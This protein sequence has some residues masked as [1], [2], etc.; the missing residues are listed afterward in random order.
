M[1]A[2]A[3]NAIVIGFAVKADNA[4]QRLA[5]TNGISIRTYTVIYRLLEDIEKALK[6]MLEPEKVEKVIGTARVLATFV[7]SRY[8]VAAGCRV[9]DGEIRR[10][11]KIRVI[12]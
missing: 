5:E 10:N 6:G 8:K 4:A 11:G 1:L 3:S 12:S 9:I 2:S 7:V